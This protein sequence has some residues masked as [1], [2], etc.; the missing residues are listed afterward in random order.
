MNTTCDVS[1]Y[2]KRIAEG[3]FELEDVDL[4]LITR[5][6]TEDNYWI[7]EEEMFCLCGVLIWESFK[8]DDDAEFC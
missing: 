3:G 4:D 6:I 5:I 2:I 8:G 7:S 1:D